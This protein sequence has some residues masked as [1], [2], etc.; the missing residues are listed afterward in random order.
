MR[1]I[2]FLCMALLA[3]TVSAGDLVKA[4]DRANLDTKTHPGTNFYQYACGGW[5]RAHP[6]DPQYARFGTFDQLAE[7]SRNQ[8]KDI[9]TNLGTNN[10]RGSLKQKVGD[11]YAQGMDS[12]RLN[13]EGM[14]P[15]KDY[16]DNLKT[17]TRNYFS[18]AIADMHNGIASPFFNSSVMADLKDSN[19]NMMYLTQGGLGM[20]DRDY[21]LDNDANT[22]KVR[23]AYVNYI[24]Q[25]FQLIGYKKAAATKAAQ[26]V[27]AIE[28]ELA[29]VAMTR[30]ETRDY[31]KLYNV[32]SYDQLKKSYPNINWGQYF[33]VLNISELDN[34]CVFQPKSIAKVNEMMKSL[35]EEDVREYLIFKYVD[36]ASPYLSDAFAD[37]NFDMYSRAM[38]GKQVKMPRWKHSLDVPNTLLG[39]AVGQLYVEKY[40][41]ADSKKKMQQLVDN[42]KKALGEHIATLSWMSPKTKVNALV[43]LNSFTVKIGYPDK[44]FDYSKLDIDPNKSYWENIMAARRFQAEYEY[45]QLN[46]PVDK[47]RWFMT[48]QT[49]NAYYEPSSNEICF[50]AGILQAP[51]FDPNA[52]EACNYGAIGVV[53][54]HEM[55]HGFDDQGRNFDHN[56]NMVDWWTPEDAAKFQELANKLGAQYSAEIVA[57]DVHANGTFTMGENI[58]DHGGLRVA[59][60]AFKKTEQG[61]GDA[62]IDGFTPDQRFFLSYANVWAA[63][64]TKE[65]MLRRTK[66]DPHSLG[67][68]RVNVAIRNLEEF[69]NAFNIQPEMPMWRDPADRVIIW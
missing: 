24:Q 35:K 52:D 16:I 36:A 9:I 49:V 61:K 15:L 25:L 42:L 4:V 29:K 34:L 60:S 39:E 63:N 14:V 65:E 66:V 46:K 55:T 10:P 1:K 28:T 62:M 67:V 38:S 2:I 68:N 43:K 51:Y 33:S 11:L 40:F 5:K 53:I 41:P 48:P 54:G 57:D 27:M 17:L 59:Y 44:W 12:V 13:N 23:K 7:N 6:L 45:G 19:S 37:A 47:E 31:S 50:P 58:A 32:M 3:M 21:Y 18:A 30:E 8:V 20:G 26:H 69:F 22:V 64:I 56:G